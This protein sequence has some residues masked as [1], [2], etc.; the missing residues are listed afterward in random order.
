MCVR[1]CRRLAPRR[2]ALS[3]GPVRVKCEGWKCEAC[4]T[5]RKQPARPSGDGTNCR[6]VKVCAKTCRGSDESRHQSETRIWK[7]CEKR[8]S[9]CVGST[10]RTC[11]NGKQLS[12]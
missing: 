6:C 12:A 3:G 7:P 4:A 5:L 10:K 1:A 8:G 9:A 11:R 2:A